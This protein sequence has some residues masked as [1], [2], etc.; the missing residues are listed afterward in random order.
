M[1]GFGLPPL[2][3]M[4][5]GCKNIICSDIPVLREVYEN[6]VKYMNPYDIQDIKNVC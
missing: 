1:K 5:A 2:E 4:A 6:S 3:A